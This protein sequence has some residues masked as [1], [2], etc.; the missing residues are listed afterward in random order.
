MAI[1]MLGPSHLDER[2]MKG[3]RQVF[4]NNSVIPTGIRGLPN[5]SETARSELCGMWKKAAGCDERGRRVVWMVIDW[6]CGNYDVGKLRN[7]RLWY[8]TPAK[9]GNISRAH[10]NAE[11]DAKMFRH[12]LK[13]IDH[14]IG[15]FPGIK[16]MFWCLYYRSKVGAS[17]SLPEESRYDAVADRYKD[18]VI[19]IRKYEGRHGGASSW[20]IDAGGHPSGAG[21]DL[22]LEMVRD[23]YVT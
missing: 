2:D 4:L 6:R 17:C 7:N 12:Q 11:N 10:I 3:K 14:V 16:L 15:E 5:F 21:Y 20:Y 22:I 13:L 1:Y 19:D 8:D 23:A 9:V 18:H